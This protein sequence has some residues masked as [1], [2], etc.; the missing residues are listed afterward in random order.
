MNRPAPIKEFGKVGQEFYASFTDPTKATALEVS[1]IDT[2]E[3]KP[4]E[5]EVK[6][7]DNGRWVIPSHHN[8]PADAEDR[9]ADTAASTIGIK[10]GALV[11]RW[12]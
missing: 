5:F 12:K 11:T 2:D 4:L 1:T 3:L 8:Y 6:R 9:L 7:S 10:R